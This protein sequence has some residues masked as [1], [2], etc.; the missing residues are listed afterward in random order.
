MDGRFRHELNIARILI[1]F[2]IQDIVDE[3]ENL[4]TDGGVLTVK[5]LRTDVADTAKRRLFVKKNLNAQFGRDGAAPRSE[6]RAVSRPDLQPSGSQLEPSRPSAAQPAPRPQ[7]VAAP[8]PAPEFD[9]F[10]G[11]A[12]PMA[13]AATAPISS[14]SAGIDIDEGPIIVATPAAV[15]L[16]RQELQ[17]KREEA[18][19]DRVDAAL[20][21]KLEV[22]ELL[23]QMLA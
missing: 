1:A 3:K 14:G 11:S 22:T 16:D 20:K 9:F 8:A 12:S 2:N 19:Q 7:P 6:R 21:E 5:V 4:P 23:L 17:E 13:T 10:S 18:I 15:V